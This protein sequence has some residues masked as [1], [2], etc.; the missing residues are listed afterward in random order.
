MQNTMG[1]FSL[2]SRSAQDVV[3]LMPKG[4]INDMGAVSLERTSEQMLGKGMNSLI[5]NFSNVQYINTIGISIFTGMVQKT[6]EHHSV[7]CFTNMKKAH[8]DVFEMMGLIKHVM[9]FADEEDAITYL[10]RKE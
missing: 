7:L 10:K 1:N 4:Y 9:V 6:L 2:S 3:V 8:R 5:V